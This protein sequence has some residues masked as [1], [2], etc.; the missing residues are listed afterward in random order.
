MV[1]FDP[2]DQEILER[3]LGAAEAAVRDV[4][5]PIEFDSDEELERA[6]RR[7]LIEI[8]CTNGVSDAESL[9]DLV[10]AKLLGEAA[11]I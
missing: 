7:E 6:L 3:A 2:L 1:C 5:P 4:K 10:L 8:A 9:R 11:E